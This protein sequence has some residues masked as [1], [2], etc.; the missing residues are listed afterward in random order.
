MST[1][2]S[3][4][5]QDLAKW[6]AAEVNVPRV[7]IGRLLKILK[8]HIPTLP[9]SVDAL[10]PPA[11]LTYEN[12]SCGKYVHFANWVEILKKLLITQT[13]NTPTNNIYDFKLIIN[14]DGLPLFKSSGNFKL[15][16]ILVKI[17]TVPSKPICVGLYSSERA[18]NREMP[19]SN[20]LLEKFL[21]DI[22]QLKCNSEVINIDGKLFKNTHILFVCDAPARSAIKKIK[23]HTGY[24][25][26]E[27]CIVKGEYV[28]GRVS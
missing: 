9:S 3:T 17:N 24:H 14:I 21:S 10:I 23:S 5:T 16:P 13:L 11:N 15:Y 4:P 26:C 7:A 28:M 2:T 18:T 8:P 27:R 6:A 20:I 22:R 19:D 1:C 12:M 25:S